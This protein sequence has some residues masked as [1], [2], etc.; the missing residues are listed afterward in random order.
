MPLAY[1]TTP[2]S[3]AG[4][5]GV[6]SKQTGTVAGDLV[7]IFTADLNDPSRT[8][9]CPTFA[10][11]TVAST[12]DTVTVLSRVCDGTEGATFTMSTSGTAS[13]FRSIIAT[14]SGGA[15][16]QVNTALN[17]GSASTSIAVPGLTVT[18]TG[19]WTLW[20]ARAGNGSL[21]IPSGYTSRLNTGTYALADNQ[22]V[23]TGATGT[24]TGTCS[25]VIPQA[26]LVAISPAVTVW[27]LSGTA[28]GVTVT[29]GALAWQATLA[30]S[31]AHAAVTAGTFAWT[32]ALAGSAAGSTVTAGTLAA[33]YALAGS[34]VTVAAAAGAFTGAA[35]VS[36]TAAGVPA[37]AGTLTW[38]ATLTGT[39][40][41]PSAATGTFAGHAGLAGTAP[42]T[43]V[44]TDV[45]TDA[46]PGQQT[47]AGTL[48]DSEPAAGTA[49]TLTATTGALTGTAAA[50]G[51]A[52][53]V[54]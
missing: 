3:I 37:A 21:V 43:S 14:I 50:A 46:H 23:A 12:G 51:T 9:T 25:S 40:T 44:Y 31:G 54:P 5:S 13:N 24:V 49:T 7:L 28:A 33:A 41:T 27:V 10:V 4:G 26:A 16:F 17:P 32:V 8:I 38:Q 20:F 39:A 11:G 19:S 18:S 35:A 2:A 15:V 22:T 34:G 48:A 30:G 52:A 53:A 6:I 45:Y 1:R 42:L 29:T 36:G 47:A